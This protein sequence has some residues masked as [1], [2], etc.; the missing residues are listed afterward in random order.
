VSLL[1][2]EGLR[3]ALPGRPDAIGP[4]DFS[5]AAGQGLGLVG[6]SGSGKS[7]ALLALLGLLPPAAQARGTLCFDGRRFDLARDGLAPL[8][9]RALGLVFQDALACLHP[10]RTVGDQLR[11]T[12]RTH[13]SAASRSEQQARVFELL[14]EVRLPDPPR[15]LA[16]LPHQLSGGQRQ[17]VMIALALAAGPR[18]LLADEPTS[19]LDVQVQ[20][21][22]VALL[23]TLQRERGL[24][25]LFVGHDLA[26]VGALCEQL[27]VLRD[28]RVV[29]QGARDTL[30]QAP[31]HE[32]TRRLVAAQRPPP[33]AGDAPAP[34]ATPLLQVTGLAV[35]YPRA[36]APAVL[37]A[38]FELHRGRTL[39]LV[40]ESGSGKSTLGRAVLRL[41]EPL[42]GASI[43]FAGDELTTRRGAALKPARRRLAA[44]FQDP[45]SSLDPRQRVA[46]IL[47]EPLR[48]HGLSHERARLAALLA[49]VELPES[50]LERWPHQLSGGQR[51]RIALARALATDPQLLVCDEA[52]SALD[53][54]VRTQVLALLQRLQRERGL[55]LLFVT[56]DLAVAA[57]LADTV[58]VMQ[59]GRIVEQGPAAQLFAAPRHPYTRALLA[60][61][62]LPR[63][64][65]AG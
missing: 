14:A 59:H 28:G 15:I 34:D 22:I 49:S 10:L 58:A 21:E 1:A 48:I 19:A 32:Y 43:R 33:R 23:H 3:I 50:A 36:R 51:Q 63:V 5:L 31:V 46:Q 2:V 44:V 64:A 25:L 52:V 57:A 40:G 13:L 60:A 4:L 30:L 53:A 35:R 26:V 56:H 27:V 8:R 55:A 16:A 17:R 12:V 9:G 6:E 18:V 45:Y 38:A 61:A 7:L 24:G 65:A 29:E 62:R 37:D 39:A 20:Q 41:Q 47:A 11:E 54:L 42:P